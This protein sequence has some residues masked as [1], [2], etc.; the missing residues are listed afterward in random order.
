MQ[1]ALVQWQAASTG[2]GS[3]TGFQFFA[4]YELF[5]VFSIKSDLPPT[6]CVA[7]EVSWKGSQ[8]TSV[9]TAP[10]SSGDL[11]LVVRL[12]ERATDADSHMSTASMAAELAKLDELEEKLAE[13]KDKE[14]PSVVIPLSGRGLFN[15]QIDA[16]LDEVVANS[17]SHDVSLVAPSAMAGEGPERVD[18]GSRTDL[19]LIDRLWL[20]CQEA[21]DSEQVALAL[22]RIFHVKKLSNTIFIQ[23]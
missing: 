19:D 21:A 11:T 2:P 7:L 20:L 22:A 3:S 17:F 9:I 18:V 6:S 13:M 12:I 23:F 8:P 14:D 16:F 4:R 10:S 5:G 1:E 15:S